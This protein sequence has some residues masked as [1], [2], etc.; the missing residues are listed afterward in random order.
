[1]SYVPVRRN[2]F[3]AEMT[4]MGFAHVDVKGTLELV[5][6]RKIPNS[7]YGVRILSTIDP[8]S[9]VGRSVGTDAIRVTLWNYTKDRPVKVEKR[10][11]RTGTEDGVLQRTRERAR[12][13][14]GYAINNGCK[15]GN[16]IMVNRGG[17]NGDFLGCSNFPECKN[18]AQIE[19]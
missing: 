4:D 8:R 15:C 7:V 2:I 9:G 3:E 11:N 1:M 19:E 18:T 17:K 13:V 10:V 14:W 12:E 6:E 16:G 5:Y